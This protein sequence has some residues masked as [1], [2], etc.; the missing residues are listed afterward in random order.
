MEPAPNRL[1]ELLDYSPE[2]GELR[3]RVNRGKCKAGRLIAC[4]N[5]SGYIIVRIDDKLL[6][7]HRVA[8]AMTHGEWPSLEIDHINGVRNDNRIVN[9]RLASRFQNMQN[10]GKPTTNKSG[11]KG[12][13]WHARANKWQ[14][15][16]RANGK[17]YSLGLFVDP[18][19]AHNA[20]K[21][22]GEKLHDQ[23]KNHG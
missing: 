1:C 19:E 8:W 7:A 16:I 5:G 4:L 11:F 13:S 9:L 17:S 23:F 6:R 22:A 12:V 2:T 15:Y 14:A 3:W 20:Y 18:E 10:T 21:T